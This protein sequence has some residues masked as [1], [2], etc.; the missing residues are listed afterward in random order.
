MKYFDIDQYTPEYKPYFDLPK[1]ATK[2]DKARYMRASRVHTAG[3]SYRGGTFGANP[4]GV[5]ARK[6]LDW[7]GL[8]RRCHELQVKWAAANKKF[9]DAVVN[10]RRAK[11]LARNEDLYIFIEQEWVIKCHPDGFSTENA[12][13]IADKLVSGDRAAV[14]FSVMK[15]EDGGAEI[16][17]LN[18][19]SNLLLRCKGVYERILM[20]ALHDRL[21]MYVD[22]IRIPNESRS[23]FP[24]QIYIIENEGRARVA[25]SD[26]LGR[27]SWID[28][29]V[30]S[31]RKP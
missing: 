24:P 14:S 9:W 1:R 8:E 20:R 29:D 15:Y 11:G 4:P 28:G 19:R 16:G 18:R 26:S 23:Y 13:Y 22:T 31:T 7:R 5:E 2:A 17:Y 21:N 6:V 3:P 25:Q 30:Y 12:T 10:A 27:I